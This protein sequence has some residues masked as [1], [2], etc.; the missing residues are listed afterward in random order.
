M[1]TDFYSLLNR[2]LNRQVCLTLHGQTNVWGRVA[3]V[4]Y[5]GLR[6]VDTVV[7]GELDSSSQFAEPR[8]PRSKETLIHLNQVLAVTCLD[9]DLPEPATEAEPRTQASVGLLVDPIEVG[10]GVQLYRHVAELGER[11]SRLRHQVASD[12]GLLLPEIQIRSTPTVEANGYLIRL[13]GVT[14]EEGTVRLGSLLALIT[15]PLTKTINQENEFE[16]PLGMSGVWIDR[17]QREVAEWYGYTVVE[18]VDLIAARLDRLFRQRAPDLFGRQQLEDLLDQVRVMAPAIV[19]EVLPELIRPRQLQKILRNLLREGVPVRDMETILEALSDAARE[20]ND[21]FELT[22]RVRQALGPALSQRYRDEQGTLS[23]VALDPSLE[24]ALDRAV[25]QSSRGR[26]L[27][28]TA[29]QSESVLDTLSTHLADLRA[30]GR[31]EV[32]L[33]TSRVRAALRALIAARHPH[34]IVLSHE[35]VGPDTVISNVGIVFYTGLFQS[36]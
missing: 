22:E 21:V 10:V 20:T 13:R 34:C 7:A 5:D 27:K 2:Y 23:V 16:T 25:R 35:E 18:P 32:V 12:L 17:A 9:D 6:M 3:G 19:E 1:T 28:L 30:Q 36:S 14:A 24:A 31:P 29:M 11:M 15:G 26:E 4:C 8:G 33:T